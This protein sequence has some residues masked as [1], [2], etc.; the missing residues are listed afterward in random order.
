MA[1]PA[2]VMASET[3]VGNMLRDQGL[4]RIE[5]LKKSGVTSARLGD[6]AL[7]IDGKQLPR[8]YAPLIISRAQ[9]LIYDDY[10]MRKT[11]GPH[12]RRG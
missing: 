9:E 2:G 6:V 5:D 10:M 7:D 11:F 4:E 12:W 1:A 3:W 8:S